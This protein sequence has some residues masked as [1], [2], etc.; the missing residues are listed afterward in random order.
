MGFNIDLERPLG[1]TLVDD[2]NPNYNIWES[3]V[4]YRESFR[5]DEDPR[6]IKPYGM[7]TSETSPEVKK[8]AILELSAK[9]ESNDYIAN[10]LSV[11]LSYVKQVLRREE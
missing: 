7:N 1:W 6:K 5:K 11:S 2:S 9:G 8:K 10:L 4:G 3:S